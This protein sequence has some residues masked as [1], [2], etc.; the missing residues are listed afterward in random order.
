MLDASG[1]SD[2]D[3]DMLNYQWDKVSGNATLLGTESVN[4]EIELPELAVPWNGQSTS[5]I[6]IGLTVFDCRAA[7]DDFVTVTFICNG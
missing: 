4:L 5:T 2:P 1:S 7:D 6:E 3:S